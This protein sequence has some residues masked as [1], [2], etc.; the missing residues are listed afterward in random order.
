MSR[1]R[2]IGLIIGGSIVGL[3]VIVLVAGL[4]IVQT[5]WFQNQVRVKIISSIEDATG[6]KVDIRS[7]SFDWHRLRAEIQDLVIHGLES[8]DVPPLLATKLIRVDLKLLSPFK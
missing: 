7:F 8:A 5:G 6:G 3:L 4:V 1:G 2:R